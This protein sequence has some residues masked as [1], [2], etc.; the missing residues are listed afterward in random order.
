MEDTKRIRFSNMAKFM[1]NEDQ[2]I[3]F[4]RLNGQWIKVPKQCYDILELCNKEGLSWSALS[5]SLADDED[6]EYM[7]QLIKLLDSMN[8]LYNDDEKIIENISFAITHRCNLKCIHCMV[9]AAFGQSDKEHFD[10]K[11]ICAFLDKIVAANPKNITLT[12][13]EPLLRSDFLTILGYLR[14]IYNGKITLMTNGTLITPK[15]VKEIVSQI[16]SIDISLDG[17]DEESCA[18][19]RGKGVFEKVVSSIKLLQSHGFSKISISM[20]LSAN[21]VRYTKQFMELNES[22]NTTPMLRALSYEGRAKE[23]KD[24]LD[25]V[26]TTEFL[27]QEDKKT[28]SE[29]RTCCCTAGYNQITIEA[30]GDIFPC[31]LFV[32]PEF[33]LGTMSEIDDLRKLF[34][35]NTSWTLD[36]YF[37]FS[38]NSRACAV[39]SGLLLKLET[40]YN[41]ILN[42]ESAGLILEKNATRNDWTE[43]DI[44]AFTDTYVIGHQ[45]VCD[46]SVLV[47]V[48]QILSDIMGWG[49]NIVVDL[50]TNLFKNG[51]IHTNK[52]KQLIIDLEKQFG[53]TINHSNIKYTSLCSINSIGKLIGGIVDEKTKI[54]S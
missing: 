41:M 42:L 16:D 7:K 10:T 47:A 13:G 36:N 28:N 2:A 35:T 23:N 6:R 30:N 31:N 38:G 25:N 33:R 12:G 9:N 11:T 5:E 52:I 1:F 40:D 22:L 44:V 54:D 53:I 46:Q 3:I 15:N 49:D 21:N 14:S 27:R 29:C 51:L 26:V 4:N 32:E 43:N 17:A 45:Q 18:V 20:V 34:Y 37:M 19:I 48:H 39:I 24:I 50:N 8:C